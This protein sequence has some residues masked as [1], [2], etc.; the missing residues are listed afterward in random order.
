MVTAQPVSS[1]VLT[2]AEQFELIC[3]NN[4]TRL[5]NFIRGHPFD[6]DVEPYFLENADL[7]I[8]MLYNKLYNL[9]A[10]MVKI[11]TLRFCNIVF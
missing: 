7:K 3:L 2:P 9:S 1:S 5:I 4:N 8:V 6:P 11:L 10:K